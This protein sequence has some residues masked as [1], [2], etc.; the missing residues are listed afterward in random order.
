MPST[1]D[2]K[3]K[4]CLNIDTPEYPLEHFLKWIERE[5]N[6]EVLRQLEQVQRELYQDVRIWQEAEAFGNASPA[7]RQANRWCLYCAQVR[8]YYQAWEAGS[9]QREGGK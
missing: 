4:L 9:R 5:H 3:A 6:K 1:E 8:A 2:I 7:R